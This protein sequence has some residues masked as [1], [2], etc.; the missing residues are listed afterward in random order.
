MV[1]HRGITP[2]TAE[3]KTDFSQPTKNHDIT[4]RM[5]LSA[6]KI[7]LE[8]KNMR[9]APCDGIFPICFEAVSY[10]SQPL[11]RVQTETPLPT[12]PWHKGLGS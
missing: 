12:W 2:L 4:H 5:T 6:K 10:C 3:K 11:L 9:N 8:I 1:T 7:R